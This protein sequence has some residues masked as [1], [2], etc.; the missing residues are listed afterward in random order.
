MQTISG[1]GSCNVAL[2]YYNHTWWTL[3]IQCAFVKWDLRNG[4]PLRGTNA[5]F[6]TNSIFVGR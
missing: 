1:C 3:D 4:M 5:I 2:Y 6:L